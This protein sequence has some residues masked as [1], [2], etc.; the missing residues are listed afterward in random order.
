[1]VPDQMVLL[2]LLAVYGAYYASCLR[3]S[4][5]VRSNLRWFMSNVL[6]DLRFLPKMLTPNCYIV[7]K[8]R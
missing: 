4:K 6:D 5:I 7:G 8:V 3:R 1:M 2:D